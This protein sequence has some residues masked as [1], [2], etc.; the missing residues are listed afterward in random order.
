[1]KNYLIIIIIT[2]SIIACKEKSE[3]SLKEDLVSSQ[4]VKKHLKS[5]TDSITHLQLE[6][7]KNTLE[8]KFDDFSIL[9]DS[10][11]IWDNENKLKQIQKDTAFVFLELGETIE[12]KTFKIIP[13]GF[14]KIAIYQ[15]HKNSI[16]IMDEGPHCDL[17][18][19][20]HYYSNWKKLYNKNNI[21]IT[22]SYS[23]DHWEK[24]VSYT[25]DELEKT[26]LE[27]CGERWHKLLK[28]LDNPEFSPVGVSMSRI[29]L[30]I[31]LINSNTGEKKE[32]TISFEIPMG[33]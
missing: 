23:Q 17:L 7:P 20:K 21:F 9:L 11:G 6:E 19:W 8:I 12:G 29:F 1:M 30:K 14:D 15:R 22:D 32:E 25:K 4:V 13:N 2:L 28:N 5:K 26:V 10:I 3:N 27:Y 33:C 16:T 18:N 31:N 24:F